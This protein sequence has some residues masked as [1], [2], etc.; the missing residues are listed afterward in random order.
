MEIMTTR[1]HPPHDRAA[2]GFTLPAILVVTGALF[3]LAVAILLVAG[4]ERSTARSFVDRQ[5][6]ELAARAG[7]EEIRSILNQETANDDFIVLQ[8]APAR[9]PPDGCQPA[10]PLFLIRGRAD[11]SDYA[12][13][14]VPLFSTAAL[15]PD[16]PQLTPPEVGPLVGAGAMQRIDFMTLPYQDKASAAWLP[17]QDDRGRMVARYAYWVEDLQGK[18]DPRLAGNLAGPDQTHI[19]AA[20]PFPAPGL[21]PA[22]AAVGVVPLDQIALFAIDPA[23][24]SGSQGSLATALVH[25]RSLLLSPGSTLAAGH[26]SAPL[27]RDA[28]T[29]RLAEMTA[30]AA[31]ENLIANLEPYEERPVIPFVLGI[32]AGRAGTPRLNLNALLAKPPATA[33]DEMAA[34]I[35]SAL[36]DFDHRK[37]GFPEDYVKTLAA[38]AIDYADADSSPTLLANEYR[39]LDA[40]PL[41]SEIALQV[42]YLGIGDHDNRKIM[43]FCFKLFAELCNPTTQVV[44][45]AA[46]LSYEVALPM[47]GIG[48]GV[49]GEP[50]DSPSVIANPA[51][52]THDLTRI[53]GL[54]WS[55]PVSVVLQPNQYLCYHFADVTCRMD[56]G[57]ASDPIPDSTPFSLN[58]SAGASGVSLMWNGAVV[59]RVPRILR[60]QG[61]IYYINKQGQPMSGFKVGRPDTLTKAALP[62]WVYADHPRMYYNMGDPRI[63]HYLRGTQLDES[64]YPQNS[65]PNRRNVRLDIY[66]EDTADKPKIY[67]RVLPSEWPDGGHNVAVGSWTPGT[68][69]LTEMTDPKFAFP[70]EPSMRKSAPQWISNAGRFFSATEL[71][72]VFDPIMHAPVFA[73]SD[74]TEIFRSKGKMPPDSVSWPDV[75]SSEPSPF[76]G[77]GNTLRIGRPEHPAFD[78]STCP[79]LH[80]AHLLDLFHV[81]VSRSDDPAKREGPLIH[82]EG[83]VNLNTASRDVLRALAAGTLVMDPM[84]ARRL[85]S[86][87]LGAPVMAP[88]TEP[89]NLSALT[90]S[91][92]AD[93][94][95][96]AILHSRPYGSTAGLALARESSGQYVFGNRALYQDRSNI[97]WT[98]AAAEETFARVY[99]AATV[100]SRNFRVWVVAQ[101]LA[102]SLTPGTSPP[103]L[104]EVRKV[105]ALFAD[106]GKRAADGSIIPGNCQ[107]RITSTHDF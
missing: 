52:T 8:S 100:R 35:R 40:C 42:N 41:M 89:L 53:D 45:G 9:P 49:G 70:Y 92:E 22:P 55:Q 77:G 91:L 57:A 37:G 107:T 71:G 14:Y 94:I 48:T 81:G 20:W 23:A 34:L 96:D 80:A 26:L 85:N 46:R 101:T 39:G 84:L 19:R 1:T 66:K 44:E 63:T 36:P 29:G 98:D 47:D 69:D 73:S 10:P 56:V 87:H 83:H 95:A 104:A 64:V 59:E 28:A 97:E 60:Q 18:L 68:Q 78:Q 72:H 5:R 16:R 88:P 76:Y 24:H 2:E 58:E 25:H 43:T 105:F 12:Y 102:P 4:L 79:G 75:V 67:A 54:Y 61:L 6:A 38:N 103:V 90:A 82:I 99:E 13:H 31:E 106:P 30:R 51:I 33:V 93:R 86:N 32:D 15:P 65:S 3:I 7:L 27:A 50:F 21:N 17:V 74:A 62:G 11:G